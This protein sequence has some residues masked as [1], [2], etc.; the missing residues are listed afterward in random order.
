MVSDFFSSFP[1]VR[2]LSIHALVSNHAHS[3]IVNGNSMILSA[4]NLGSCIYLLNEKPTHISWC[5]R[6]VLGVVRVP[7]SRDSKISHSH[8]AL[9]IKYQVFRFDIS[10]QNALPMKKLQA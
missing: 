4:H 10:V 5:A 9:V 2:S 6:G 1:G 3:K 8:I 7:H